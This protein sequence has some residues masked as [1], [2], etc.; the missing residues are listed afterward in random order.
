MC[1]RTVVNED[2]LLVGVQVLPRLGQE[3]VKAR[4]IHPDDLGGMKHQAVNGRYCLGHG[5]VPSSLAAYLSICTLTLPHPPVISGSPDV[6]AALIDKNTVAHNGMNQFP[7]SCLLCKTSRLFVSAGTDRTS[8]T[9]KSI[10]SKFRATVR[11]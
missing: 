6:V 5:H 10:P 9:R 11:S 3:V 8:L 2:N 7:Y 4:Y 1:W